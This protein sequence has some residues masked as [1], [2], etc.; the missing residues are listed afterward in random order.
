MTDTLCAAAEKPEAFYMARPLEK[1]AADETLAEAVR[2]GWKFIASI[3]LMHFRP[4][5]AREP[6]GPMFSLSDGRRSITPDDLTPDHLALLS[7]VIVSSRDCEIHARIADVIWLKTKDPAFA[8]KGVRAYLASAE[9]LEDPNSWPPCTQRFERAARLARM[10]GS[11]DPALVNVLD[12]VLKKIRIYRGQDN[13]FLTN[14]L[15]ELLYEFRHGDPAELAQYTLAGAER[16]RAQPDFNRARAYYETTAK[17]YGRLKDKEGF[18]RMRLAIAETFREEAEAYE[19]VGNYLAAHV[20]WTNAILAYRKAPGAAAAVPALQA[21]LHAAAERAKQ[22][23]QGFEHKVDF[24]KQAEHAIASVAGL[25]W[26]AALTRF[27]F[28]APAIQVNELRNVTLEQLK[29]HPLQALVPV[30][31]L[32]Q[33]GRVKDRTPAALLNDPQQ[34]EAAIQAAMLRNAWLHRWHMFYGWLQP[35]FYKLTEEHSLTEAVLA[36]V[37]ASSGMV[38]PRREE[39]FVRGLAAGFRGDFL[40][41][42]CLLVPQIENSLRWALHNLGTIPGSIDDEGIEEDWPLHRCLSQEKVQQFLGADLIF[43]L[44]SLLIEKGGPNLRNLLAHGLLDASNCYSVEGFYTWW[45]VLKM[46]LATSPAIR[47]AADAPTDTDG[48]PGAAVDL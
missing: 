40:V 45:L 43:E 28:G 16:A 9:R 14:E 10:L 30:V 6:F 37:I 36:P 13:L 33:R 42:E 39:F 17:L 23:A 31:H 47:Q 24:T 1:R 48:A 46:T 38:P 32:D 4:K 26:L 41:A 5:N 8:R 44:R 27:T 20:G 35:A 29:N 19:R 7:A 15:A 3:L 18:G 11:C 2:D 25:N 22:R 12:T 21:R 34:Q